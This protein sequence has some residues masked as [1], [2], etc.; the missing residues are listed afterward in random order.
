MV[1]ARYPLDIL[2]SDVF[3]VTVDICTRSPLCTIRFVQSCSMTRRISSGLLAVLTL[4]GFGLPALQS[5]TSSGAG[6][7]VP[8]S[9][10]LGTI[11]VDAISNL[12][13]DK[14]EYQASAGQ[15]TIL[16][17]NKSNQSHTL[18]VSDDAGNKIGSMLRVQSSGN[19]SMGTYT[20]TAGA[21]NVYCNIPGHESAKAKLVVK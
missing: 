2:R 1:V 8:A 20:L 18:L 3:H 13:L 5:C 12:R 19:R 11:E 14:S 9:L 4:G 6:T 15:V 10:P 7:G 21:Y 16:Y 17:V